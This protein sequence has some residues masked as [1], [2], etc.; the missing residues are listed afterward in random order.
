ML[1]QVSSLLVTFLSLG[2]AFLSH[3]LLSPWPKQRQLSL[4]IDCMN[5]PPSEGSSPKAF[6][7]LS[8]LQSGANIGSICRNALAFNVSEVVIVGRREVKMRQ[9]D[10]GAR[11]RLRIVHFLS[12]SEAADY[13]RHTHGCRFLGIEICEEADSL[14]AYSFRHD[15]NY[16]FI[17]GNEGG[18]LSPR[19]RA[20]CDQFLYIPQYAPQGGILHP[21]L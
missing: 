21:H 15:N 3:S 2:L 10:R 19:Q 12:L 13:L 5:Q 11:Q 6:L 1:G 8:N 4:Q 20:I 17:F 7:L 18:G 9:A 14:M 16:C